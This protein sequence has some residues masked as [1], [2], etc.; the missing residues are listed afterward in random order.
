MKRLNKTITPG[1]SSVQLIEIPRGGRDKTCACLLGQGLQEQGVEHCLGVP[2]IGS[3][4]GAGT[5]SQGSWGRQDPRAKA[6]PSSH[7]KHFKP[8]TL[9]V[10]HSRLFC[11]TLSPTIDL[12]L[13]P[14][15]GTREHCTVQITEETPLRISKGSKTLS[16]I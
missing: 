1:S 11:F 13:N 4:C 9:P 16:L 10:P 5:Q 2:G 12:S 7:P 15:T 6:A 14:D 3:H 8:E